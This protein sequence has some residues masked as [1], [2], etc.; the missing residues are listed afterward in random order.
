MLLI[1]PE[2]PPI[3]MNDVDSENRYASILFNLFNFSWKWYANILS[4]SF[5]GVCSSSGW[6]NGQNLAKNCENLAQIRKT[7]LRLLILPRDVPNS[8]EYL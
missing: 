7:G 6:R 1:L 4:N 8:Y 3:V 5:M 2:T